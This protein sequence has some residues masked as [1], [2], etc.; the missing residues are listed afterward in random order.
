[1]SD[2]RPS[3]NFVT[4]TIPAIVFI[5][6]LCMSIF[7]YSINKKLEQQKMEAVF[8]DRAQKISASV[9]SWMDLNNEILESI[10]SFYLSSDFVSRPE[11][12][13]FVA[14][15]LQRHKNI[16]AIN[17]IPRVKF[18]DRIRFEQDAVNDGLTGFQFTEEKQGETSRAQDREEYYP[19]F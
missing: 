16:W 3:K 4:K 6:G 15:Y 9:E 17:W 7:A 11:F 2:R 1:M 14:G 8:T 12:R 13:N 18:N 19:V 5:G 10:E